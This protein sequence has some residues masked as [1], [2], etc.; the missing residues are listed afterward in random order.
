[1]NLK[2]AIILFLITLLFCVAFYYIKENIIKT[3][4]KVITKDYIYYQT[5]I[6][7]LNEQIDSLNNLNF[8]FQ[9]IIS[10]YE[11]TLEILKQEDYK[12]ANKFELIFNNKTE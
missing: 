10:K 5:E 4:T 8:N 3:N 7:S 1:M 12:T 9:T 2:N 6:D 11:M